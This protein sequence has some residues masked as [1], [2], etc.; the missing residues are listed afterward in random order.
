MR[1][2]LKGLD[3][4]DRRVIGFDIATVEYGRPIGLPVCRPRGDGLFEVRSN[5][6]G[7]RIARVLFATA[8]RRLVLLHGFVMKAQKTPKA[9]LELARKRMKEAGS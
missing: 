2:W 1:D 6:P 7:G 5:L 9:D 4:Q 8:E 3:E